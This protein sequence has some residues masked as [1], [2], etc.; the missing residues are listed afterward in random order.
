MLSCELTRALFGGQ[1]FTPK[2]FV[3]EVT[4]PPRVAEN[5]KYEPGKD[6]LPYAELKSAPRGLAQT[7]AR[8]GPL[9]NC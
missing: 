6:V 7:G 9:R 8:E 5:L 3:P 1:P 4:K 2:P